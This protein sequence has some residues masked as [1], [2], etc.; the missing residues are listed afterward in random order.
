MKGSPMNRRFAAGAAGTLAA[1]F[2]IVSLVVQ[3]A[4]S[5]DGSLGYLSFKDVA[6]GSTF[7]IGMRDAGPNV[8]KFQFA[9]NGTG[10]FWPSNRATVEVKSDS[11]VIVRYDGPGFADHHAT[12]DAAFG[13]HQ[14][15]GEALAVAVRLEAQVNPD[16]ITASAELW[17][18]GVAYKLTDRRATPDAVTDLASILA[19]FQAENWASVYQWTYSGVRSEMTQ[20]EFIVASQNAFSAEGT[21]VQAI[22]TGPLTYSSGGAGF[23]TATAPV[24]LT[25]S[26]GRVVIAK[27]S[28]IWEDDRWA[29]LSVAPRP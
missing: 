26:S 12:I 29:L 21:V 9:V 10:L 3:P 14:K 5:A 18:D 4:T 20:A 2:L 16:R 24:S 22:R 17:V 28:L 1:G 8:G 15:S 27:A 23:D 7:S 11:S 13:Y 25:M 19:V 6:N